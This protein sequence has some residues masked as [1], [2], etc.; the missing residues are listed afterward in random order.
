[1]AEFEHAAEILFD[2]PAE[3]G[4][5]AEREGVSDFVAEDGGVRTVGLEDVLVAPR[6]EG[7]FFL[8]VGEEAVV[9]VFGVD[10]DP[11]FVKRS[12]EEAEF[13]AGTDLEAT[14][15]GD[16]LDLLPRRE[17]EGEDVV[18]LVE[19]EESFDGDREA[20]LMDKFGH[21]CIDCNMGRG[22]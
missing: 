5:E 2:K 6:G 3:E 10:G 21:C 8:D 14:G 19:G 20:G 22:G 17:E 18:A 7:A 4:G 16:D 1:M 11:R 12:E 15:A 13:D 9:F